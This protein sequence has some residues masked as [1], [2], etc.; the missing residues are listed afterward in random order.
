MYQLA[1]PFIPS[2]IRHSF[3]SLVMA[4]MQLALQI[5]LI[6]TDT[7]FLEDTMNKTPECKRMMSPDLMSLQQPPVMPP[8]SVFIECPPS[9]PTC[10]TVQH[11]DLNLQASTLSLSCLLLDSAQLRPVASF[12]TFLTSVNLFNN[13]NKSLTVLYLSHF[14]LETISI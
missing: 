13:Y 4:D 8:I 5:L 9:T 11:T 14:M 10:L 2:S 1:A 7:L 6:P 3:S 12:S